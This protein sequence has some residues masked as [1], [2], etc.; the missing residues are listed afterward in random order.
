MCT[1]RLYFLTPSSVLRLFL[2]GIRPHT[3]L[4]PL[5]S[6]SRVP[7]YCQTTGDFPTS[8]SD[9]PDPSLLFSTWLLGQY[10]FLVLP[11]CGTPHFHSW[12]LVFPAVSYW[13]AL[14]SFSCGFT[15]GCSPPISWLWIKCTRRWILYFSL[16]Y[17]PLP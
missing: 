7:P 2:T 8:A 15:P 6:S 16:Q 12:Q 17:R 10:P 3:A 1:H 14:H 13:G 9:T 11:H 4:K 5:Q